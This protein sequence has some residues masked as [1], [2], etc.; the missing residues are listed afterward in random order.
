MSTPDSNCSFHISRL[1]GENKQ[2]ILIRFLDNNIFAY[3]PDV[4][5]S[6]LIKNQTLFILKLKRRFSV[7]SKS[8]NFQLRDIFSKSFQFIE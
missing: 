6:K 8:A 7:I 2:Q 1:T 5:K 3:V 4:K